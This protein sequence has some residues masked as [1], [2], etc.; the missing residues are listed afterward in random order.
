MPAH[1]E[2]LLTGDDGPVTY[3]S[4]HT[5]QWV[6]DGFD[7]VD[8]AKVWPFIT[9]RTAPKIYALRRVDNVQVKTPEQS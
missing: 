5:I 7:R 2:W 3:A 9:I 8:V 1:F 6:Q 4:T